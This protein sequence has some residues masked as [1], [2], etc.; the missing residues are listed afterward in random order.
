MQRDAKEK[1]HKVLQMQCTA[2]CCYADAVQSS[3][4]VSSGVNTVKAGDDD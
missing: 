3:K 4:V 1:G 2:K